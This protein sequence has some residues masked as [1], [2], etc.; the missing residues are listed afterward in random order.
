MGLFAEC[1]CS[2]M[3]AELYI[4]VIFFF[5][6]H[7]ILI[8]LERILTFYDLS[9]VIYHIIRLFRKYFE[10]HLFLKFK[11]DVFQRRN[12]VMVPKKKRHGNTN[13]NFFSGINSLT[14]Y[15]FPA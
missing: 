6:S 10:K 4:P 8:F 3:I 2:I 5:Q 9:L 7:K 12:I 11:K 13:D 15:T 14:K 1:L